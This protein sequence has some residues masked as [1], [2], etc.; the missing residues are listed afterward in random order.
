MTLLFLVIA[1]I[2]SNFL[3]LALTFI[4]WHDRWLNGEAPTQLASD[5]LKLEYRKRLTVRAAL[6]VGLGCEACNA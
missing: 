5:L 2:M 4:F 6:T 1:P 3:P